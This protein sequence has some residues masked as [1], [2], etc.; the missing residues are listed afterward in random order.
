MT[1]AAG[2][3]TPHGSRGHA[4][5]IERTVDRRDQVGAGD[6]PV[7]VGIARRTGTTPVLPSAM[8]T[9]AMSSFTVQSPPKV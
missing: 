7:A 9:I 4:A 3:G 6:R 1:G 2:G 8:L 5:A